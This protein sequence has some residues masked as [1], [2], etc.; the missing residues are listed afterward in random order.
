MVIAVTGA[1]DSPSGFLVGMMTLEHMNRLPPPYPR[2]ETINSRAL[3]ERV[4]T[5]LASQIEK[6]RLTGKGAIRFLGSEK[7]RKLF[8]LKFREA[9]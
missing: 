3:G 8:V 2:L 7:K 4:N 6:V 9:I 1:V 5:N